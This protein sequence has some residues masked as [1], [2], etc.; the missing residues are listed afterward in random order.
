[1]KSKLIKNKESGFSGVDIV[2]SMTLIVICVPIITTLFVNIYMN[3]MKV[4]RGTMANFYATQILEK[5]SQTKYE[6]VTED[7]IQNIVN[8]LEIPKGYTVN[9]KLENYNE[10][11]KNKEDIIKI[12]TVNIS[13]NIQENT[14]L[15][16]IRTVKTKEK[17]KEEIIDGDRN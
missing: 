15:L 11:F 13:Y 9:T 12:I 4:K 8:S 16:S 3:W 2:I 6:N 10:R 14:E 5:V 7:E 1:M 17:V